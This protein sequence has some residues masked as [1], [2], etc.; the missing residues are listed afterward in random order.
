MESTERIATAEARIDEL[1]RWQGKQNGSLEKIF[2]RLDNLCKI[3]D[4]Q[5]ELWYKY[6]EHRYDSCPIRED[7]EQARNDL[8]KEIQ[9]VY[10]DIDAKFAVLIER[11]DARE[12]QEKELAISRGELLTFKVL[13]KIGGI[14]AVIIGMASGAVAV[15]HNLGVF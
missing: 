3:I 5:K 2:S 7:M 1:F 11:M 14:A 13:G 10:A 12:R 8:N 6:R 4:E 15:L 9:R